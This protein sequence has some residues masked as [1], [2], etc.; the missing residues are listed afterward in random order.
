M[1]FTYS[2][3][4]YGIF[5]DGVSL[6]KSGNAS[7]CSIFLVI[8]ELKSEE[9]YK[10]ERIKTLLRRVI[11]H[12]LVTNLMDFGPLGEFSCCQGEDV[13]G[14]MTHQIFWTKN[15]INQLLNR[16]MKNTF[17]IDVFM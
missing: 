11:L 15:V 4:L 13:N 6:W 1:F 16:F 9:R 10:I 12:P 7:L 3:S 5:V 2:S 17:K 8:N 14:K